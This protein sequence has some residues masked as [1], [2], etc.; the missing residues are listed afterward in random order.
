MPPIVRRPRRPPPNADEVSY[1]SRDYEGLRQ[2]M[3]D[4][5]SVTLPA[6]TERHVPDLWV[7]LVELLAYVGDDLSY[8]EDAVATEAYLQ[9][10]R[11]RISIRR[12]ARLLGTG[13]TTAAAP[14]PGSACP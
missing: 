11:R 4:R 7:T 6:F 8:Y 14:G 1:L 5:L 12:H 13:C 2:L 10:A 9:T 3:L